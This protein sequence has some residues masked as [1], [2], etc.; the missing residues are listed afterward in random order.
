MRLIIS[1]RILACSDKF[2][3][4]LQISRFSFRMFQKQDR[5][6]GKFG[7]NLCSKCVWNYRTVWNNLTPF[8]GSL[9]GVTG[10]LFGAKKAP[11]VNFWGVTPS[12]RFGELDSSCPKSLSKV[13]WLFWLGN[14]WA[15]ILR[16]CTMFVKSGEIHYTNL[17]QKPGTNIDEIDDFS[18]NRCLFG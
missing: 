16:F 8:L 9:L 3:Q 2:S 4:L 1:A 14:I 10:H 13:G 5:A 15:Q 12:H 17:L 6:C 7:T 18:S 11:I